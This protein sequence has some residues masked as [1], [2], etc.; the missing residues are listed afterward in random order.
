MRRKGINQQK[1][2]FCSLILSRLAAEE[3]DVEISK[4][5]ISAGDSTGD[6]EILSS[7]RK[8][9]IL[10]KGIYIYTLF[11]CDWLLMIATQTEQ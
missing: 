6:H 8:E 1:A 7:L 10:Q 11:S 4:R 2:I 9:V 3:G 5:G